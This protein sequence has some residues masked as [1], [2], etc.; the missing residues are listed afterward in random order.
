M[1]HST[2][3]SPFRTTRIIFFFQI[4]ANRRFRFARSSTL[5]QHERP[6]HAEP[7]ETC[8]EPGLSAKD[9]EDPKAQ[10]SNRHECYK[11]IPAH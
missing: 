2:F 6:K 4:Q 8:S 11:D 3:F 5:Q 10:R 9:S 7:D 1:L